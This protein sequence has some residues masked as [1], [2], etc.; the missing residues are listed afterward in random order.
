MLT[1]LALDPEGAT[2]F[3]GWW[4]IDGEWKVSYPSACVERA[5]F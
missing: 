4:G 2:L 5:V 1:L 3:A